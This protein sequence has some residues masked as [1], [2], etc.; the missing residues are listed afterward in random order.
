VSGETRS[1]ISGWTVDTLHEH[2]VSLL[3]DL[4]QLFTQRFTDSEK[5]A[6]VALTAVKDHTKSSFE[7]SEKAIVKAEEAQKAYNTSHNDL[8]RKM[9]EQS[10]A[11][12]PRSETEAR[13]RALEEKITE[14]RGISQGGKNMWGYVAG[15]FAFILL[16]LSILGGVL[17]LLKFGI[18]P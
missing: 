9:D 11:T 5:A 10:K 8:A 6:A 3:S 1:S 4:E 17:T 14:L 18:K 2:V 12:M 16:L 15:G 13:F 7:A